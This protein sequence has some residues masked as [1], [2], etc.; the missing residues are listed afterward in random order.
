M[1]AVRVRLALVV[2][3]FVTLALLGW[4]HADQVSAPGDSVGAV[5][6][7][8]AGQPQPEGPTD[9]IVK[10]SATASI[11]VQAPHG[12]WRR[13]LSRAQRVLSAAPQ[14]P[15]A[16]GLPSARRSFPLLI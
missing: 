12:E 14:S 15:V 2:A 8:L 6:A 1:S 3:A 7:Q 9:A 16:A 5:S 11:T 4:R 13:D 10:P